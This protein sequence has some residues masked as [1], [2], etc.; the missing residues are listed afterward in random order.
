M[1]NALYVTVQYL[2]D[3]CQTSQECSSKVA[4][5]VCSTGNKCV[6]GSSYYDTNGETPAGSCLLSEA[7]VLFLK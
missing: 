2:G 6:C 7:F 5:S 1:I 3:S 4:N